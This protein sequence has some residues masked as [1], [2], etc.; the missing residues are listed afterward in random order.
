VQAEYGVERNVSQSLETL[1]GK[2]NVNGRQE[3]LCTDVSERLARQAYIL[4]VNT[5]EFGKGVSCKLVGKLQQFGHFDAGAER[6]S[7]SGH[8]TGN[9][10]T[11]KSVTTAI[12]S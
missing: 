7:G 9:G 5:L 2:N 8:A 6:Q 3:R 11:A 12:A 1:F 4:K 10:A